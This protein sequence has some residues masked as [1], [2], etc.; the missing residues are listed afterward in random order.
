MK[1]PALTW[2]E[3]E[4]LRTRSYIQREE[5]MHTPFLLSYSDCSLLTSCPCLV[6]ACQSTEL[7]RFYVC[8]SPFLS[9]KWKGIGGKASAECLLPQSE[10]R[11][12]SS[13]FCPKSLVGKGPQ[14]KACN[15]FVEAQGCQYDL[16]KMADATM[17]EHAT[18]EMLQWRLHSYG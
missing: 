5:F 4:I 3:K 1:T 18:M 14:S 11:D 6:L 16:N 10:G 8:L 2:N 7:S 12:Q 15:V 17:E 13:H 9:N